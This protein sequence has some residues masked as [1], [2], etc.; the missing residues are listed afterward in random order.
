[1]ITIKQYNDLLQELRPAVLTAPKGSEILM[2]ESLFK[3]LNSVMDQLCVDKQIRCYFPGLH[4]QVVVTKTRLLRWWIVKGQ[5]SI[6]E[7]I[8][9]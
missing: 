6:N 3:E 4:V 9:T 7:A 5:G 2:T 8:S 1:M